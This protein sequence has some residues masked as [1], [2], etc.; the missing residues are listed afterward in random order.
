ML[1]KRIIVNVSDGKVSNNPMDTLA[2]FSLG[3][4]IGVCLY[5]PATR[6]GGMLHYQLP[7]STMDAERAKESPMM[8]ADTGMQILIRKM[9]SLGAN[10]KRMQIKIA[11]GAAMEDGPKGFD[12]GKRNHLAI[13][14][15]LWQNSM[16]LDAEDV[17][18]AS[19]RNLY[20]NIADGAVTVKSSRLERG[21]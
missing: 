21:L 5:D 4:C 15:V 19:P 16:F 3:S 12:I 17:G 2:T 7:N 6:I 20:M 10:K 13:K 1:N 8:F 11:G 14:K 18:G 9:L